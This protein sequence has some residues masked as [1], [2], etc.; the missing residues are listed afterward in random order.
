MES[1]GLTK[2]SF[3]KLTIDYKKV[4]LHKRDNDWYYWRSKADWINNIPPTK[5]DIDQ[6]QQYLEVDVKSLVVVHKEIEL[7]KKTIKDTLQITET[8]DGDHS[9][10]LPGFGKYIF[11]EYI[12]EFMQQSYRAATTVE[13]YEDQEVSY[14]GAFTASNKYF[15]RLDEEIFKQRYPNYPFYDEDNQPII[16]SYDVN[17]LYPSVMVKGLPINNALSIENPS[18]VWKDYITW[19]EITFTDLWDNGYWY[20]W[21]PKYDC[22]NN[23]F[24]GENFLLSFQKLMT[25]KYV[26]KPLFDKFIEMCDSHVEIVGIRYQEISH[27]MTDF[28]KVLYE[29]KK[30]NQHIDISTGKPK[31]DAEGNDMKPL[32]SLAQREAVKLLLNSLYGKLGEKFKRHNCSWTNNMKRKLKDL[33]KEYP[34]TYSNL[35]EGSQRYKSKIPYKNEESNCGFYIAPNKRKTKD[36]DG[37][38]VRES[39]LAGLYVTQRSRWILMSAIKDEIDQGNIV[40]NCDT[41]SLKLIQFHKP[42]FPIDEYELGAWKNEGSFTEFLHCNKLKKYA[43]GNK[44]TGVIKVASGGVPE[45]ALYD[46]SDT[47]SYDQTME[48]LRIVFDVNNVVQIKS[49][50]PISKRNSSWQIIITNSDYIFR[51]DSL[52]QPIT[53][54]L[55][56]RVVNKIND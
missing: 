15:L 7:F 30:N 41:D 8:I 52:T 16:K 33:K 3:N 26:W 14:T 43:L 32:Y 23:Y 2:E 47:E 11:E 10:T 13:D 27:K 12:T 42:K 34:E 1:V 5:L 51:R 46:K 37:N 38:P 36:A 19:Y 24:F 28:I 25:Q 54:V 20:A 29:V 40:L 45:I 49:C 53:H 56:D 31:K 6:E 55:V 50:K 9:L 39:I 44:H 21:K 48:R 18:E 4:N 22:L 17:S 35:R